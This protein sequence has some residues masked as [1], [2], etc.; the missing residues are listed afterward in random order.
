M[1]DRPTRQV[2]PEDAVL[3][4]VKVARTARNRNDP[5]NVIIPSSGGS[6]TGPPAGGGGSGGGD[7]SITSVPF[8]YVQ[9][10]T[11]GSPTA[12]ETWLDTS[13]TPYTLKF[14]ASSAWHVVG[15][16]LSVDIAW[17]IHEGGVPATGR[18][19]FARVPF[20]GEIT[21]WTLLGDASGSVVL[22]L[23]KTTYASAP[24]TVTDTITASAKPV[25]S[26]QVKNTDTT[27]T[28]WTK[29]VSAGDVFAL[30]IDSASTLTGFDFFL[31][32]LRSS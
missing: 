24:P 32:L 6:G 12:G 30:N 29:A 14:Y 1:S 17:N 21:G 25:L 27:L 3:A 11:P 31:T 28:G 2:T 10:G 15:A 8:T 20:D 26:S 4:L 13:T 5:I 23:W 7:S 9:T 16:P 18:K 22:D 19:Y